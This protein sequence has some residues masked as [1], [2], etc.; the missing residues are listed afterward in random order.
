MDESR[1]CQRCNGA[2]FTNLFGTK[3]TC[4]ICGG[5]GRVE[6]PDFEKIYDEITVTRNGEKTLRKSRPPYKRGP[7]AYYVWRMA[8]FHGGADV[9]MPVVA[10]AEI[11]GDPYQQ[12]LDCFAEMVAKR[13]FGTDMAAVY[14]WAPLLGLGELPERNDLPES[15]YRNGPVVTEG[16]KPMEEWLEMF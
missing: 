12:E 13:F 6:K 11:H 9:C 1:T 8:R 3:R 10:E 5:S 7:R 15:A 14:R 16:E 2:G 4:R